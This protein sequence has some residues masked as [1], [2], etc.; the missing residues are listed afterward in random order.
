VLLRSTWVSDEILNDRTNASA[1][2]RTQLLAIN[3]DLPTVKNPA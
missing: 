1:E 3:P 2:V